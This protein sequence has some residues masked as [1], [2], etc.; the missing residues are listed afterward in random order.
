MRKNYQSFG[1]LCVAQT[2]KMWYTYRMKKLF[3]C[4]VAAALLCQTFTA[5]H[6][7][8]ANP[9]AAPE[10]GD[11]ATEFKFEDDVP[12]VLAG[13][14]AAIERVMNSYSKTDGQNSDAS[15]SWRWSHAHS[16]TLLIAFNEYKFYLPPNYSTEQRLFLLNGNISFSEDSETFNGKITVDGSETVSTIELLYYEYFGEWGLG[17]VNNAPYGRE[18]LDASFDQAWELSYNIIDTDI[19]SLLVFLAPLFALD[20]TD[21]EEK[22]ELQSEIPPGITAQ[23]PSGTATIVTQKN[24]LEITCD[25]FAIQEAASLIGKIPLISGTVTLR[26]EI[27]S[28]NIEAIIY[29][30]GVTV[31][32][33][34]LVTSVRFE[35]CKMIDDFTK[36]TGTIFING[37]PLSFADFILTLRGVPFFF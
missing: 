3:A 28:D 22:L 10:Y 14:V 19:E 7:P 33:L 11:A 31:E 36:S 34:P 4:A 17:L 21:I 8:H 16:A 18:K 12:Y 2:K 5:Q 1:V 32:N 29:D 6:T 20:A 25:N 35:N 30:G 27:D 23:N 37:H 15:L 24:T 9:A 26:I 13:V